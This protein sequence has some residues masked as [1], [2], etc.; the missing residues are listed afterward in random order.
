MSCLMD[1]VCQCEL[2]VESIAYLSFLDGST[3]SPSKDGFAHATADSGH[4]QLDGT[5]DEPLE[6]VSGTI[7]GWLTRSCLWAID[8]GLLLTRF[9]LLIRI[10]NEVMDSAFHLFLQPLCISLCPDEI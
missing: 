4:V 6:G 10:C 9:L 5:K 8:R 2:S 1:R 3:I 7:R